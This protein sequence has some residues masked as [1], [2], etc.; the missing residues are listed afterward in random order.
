MV[1]TSKTPRL[2]QPSKI[3][4]RAPRR[5]FQG[6]SVIKVPTSLLAKEW[7]KDDTNTAPERTAASEEALLAMKK[8][9][10]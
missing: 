4:E 10:L 6:T 1:S 7:G 9:S 3:V 8:V 2:P 5:E